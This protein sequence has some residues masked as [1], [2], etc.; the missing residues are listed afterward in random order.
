MNEAQISE[1]VKAAPKGANIHICWERPAKMR[2]KFKSE[3]FTILKRVNMTLRLCEYDAMQIVKKGRADGSKPA[4]NAGMK[5]KV[6]V[7][8]PWI[9]R[10]LKTGKLLL[11]VKLG[12]MMGKPITDS[13]KD[14]IMRVP[15]A[16]DKVIKSIDDWAFMMLAEE[17]KK[18][19]RP[20]P[21]TFDITAENVTAIHKVGVAEAIAL[22]DTVVG[23]PLG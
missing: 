17:T 2:A 11:S 10:S 3:D 15:G 21:E 4:Q 7:T 6:W 20:M 23:E 22:V 18:A 13:K 14:W 12:M 9:K 1:A 5:G 16:G 19:E 8:Y